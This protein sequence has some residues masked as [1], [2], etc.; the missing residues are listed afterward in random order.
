LDKR[1][2]GE[3]MNYSLCKYKREGS[4]S[5]HWCNECPPISEYIRIERAEI[6][7]WKMRNSKKNNAN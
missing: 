6:A 1:T 4:V 7:A 3:I 5:G 2:K